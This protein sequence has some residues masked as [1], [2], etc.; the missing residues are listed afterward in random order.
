MTIRWL[1]LRAMVRYEFLMQ[2]RLRL[3]TVVT[4]P[5]CLM[6]LLIGLSFHSF[7]TTNASETLQPSTQ[8]DAARCAAPG[9][10]CPEVPHIEAQTSADQRTTQEAS[11]VTLLTLE[12]LL[13]VFALILMPLL[14]VDVVPRDHKVKLGELLQTLPLDNG[15]YLAG[16]VGA[17]ALMACFSVTVALI[18]L[19]VTWWV[20]VYP[21]DILQYV[22]LCVVGVLP[23]AVFT[24]ALA[25]LLGSTAT[26][27]R[28]A[29]IM[30]VVLV[31][32]LGLSMVLSNGPVMVVDYLNLGRPL[33]FRYYLGLV[34]AS[35]LGPVANPVTMAQVLLAVGVG[36]VQTVALWWLFRLFLD[37]RA[38]R[39]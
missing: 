33:P 31:I 1:Q 32:F 24:V 14:V 2:W 3:W 15:T 19:G 36:L 37:R 13:H 18:F 7:R 9:T 22:A 17:A 16:K 8:G 26:T 38:A 20:L 21:F 25:V 11:T 6:V 5:L 23:V 4:I 34:A 30:G 28:R 10:N 39:A 27:R 35:T 29:W 12:L